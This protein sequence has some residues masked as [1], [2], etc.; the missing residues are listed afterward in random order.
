MTGM[1]LFAP[2]LAPYQCKYVNEKCNSVG[3]GAHKV[4]KIV[5]FW[6]KFS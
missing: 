4:G 2:W 3:A 1:V 6:Y 5:R